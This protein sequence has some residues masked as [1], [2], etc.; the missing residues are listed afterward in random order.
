MSVMTTTPTYDELCK[1]WLYANG[2]QTACEAVD[3]GSI[4]VSQPNNAW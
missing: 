4:P 3:A 1:C 2:K